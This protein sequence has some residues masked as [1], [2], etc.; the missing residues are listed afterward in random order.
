MDSDP[1]EPQYEPTYNNNPSLQQDL[2]RTRHPSQTQNTSAIN[3]QIIHAR[4]NRNFTTTRVHFNIPSSPTPNPLEL[5]SSTI[6]STHPT[7]TI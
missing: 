3:R 5:S 7:I 4:R 1:S 2:N 6:Q